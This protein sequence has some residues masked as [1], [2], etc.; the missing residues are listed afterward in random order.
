MA[1]HENIKK[2]RENKN[3]TQKQ[4]ADRLY[5]SRQTICRWESG[6][7][8]PDIIMAKKLAV[9]LEASLDDLISDEEIKILSENC[10]FFQLSMRFSNRKKLQEYQKTILN[11]IQIIG[12]VF[13]GIS[14]LL[15]QQLD[16]KIPAWCTILTLCIVGIAFVMDFK[17]QRKLK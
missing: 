17:V 1:F 15:K 6:S 4:L 2:L 7:R 10:D 12:A 16:M 3:L 5:V 8:C 14:I 13:L 9:E 11:F